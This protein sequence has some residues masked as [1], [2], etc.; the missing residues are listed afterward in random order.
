M[1]PVQLSLLP[2]ESKTLY[3]LDTDKSGDVILYRCEV[4]KVFMTGVHINPHLSAHEYINKKHA[5]KK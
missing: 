1:K 4:E 5:I 3:F 2:D